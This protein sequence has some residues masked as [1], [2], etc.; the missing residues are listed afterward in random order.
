MVSASAIPTAPPIPFSAA[1]LDDAPCAGDEAMTFN[2]N[3]P[4]AGQD[5]HIIVSS[6]EPLTYVSL[7]G[8]GNPVFVDVTQDGD[9]Y[10][11]Y[12]TANV[13]AA[14]QQNYEFVVQGHVCTT[15]STPVQSN[16]TAS[17]VCFGDEQMSYSPTTPF[18][19][20][21]LTIQ[22]TS[23][24]AHTNVAVHGVSPAQLDSVQP[25]GLGTIWTFLSTPTNNGP[26]QYAFTVD[27]QTCASLTVPV[28]VDT[29]GT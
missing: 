22:V 19:D 18:V 13:D 23:S 1:T 16:V 28:H 2:P 17:G 3:P 24:Q 4:V 27:G 20:Q 15:N 25:G 6:A 8:P 9:Q 21:Q 26:N 5:F 12:W 14:G 11:W 7:Q 29:S 10:N